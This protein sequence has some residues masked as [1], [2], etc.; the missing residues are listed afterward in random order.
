[1]N[2]NIRSMDENSAQSIVTWRYE[3]EYRIY[4]M[5]YSEQL[6]NEL[7]CGDYYA[8]FNGLTE[9]LIG[10]Y[11]FGKAAQVPVGNAFR[12]YD[13]NEYIDIGLG[14]KPDYC[15]I[16]LGLGFILQSLAFA[17]REL[18]IDRFRLTVALF[19]SR[20]IKLYK[21]IG[22]IEEISFKRTSGREDTIEFL[23]MILG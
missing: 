19:N 2:Y 21:K 5:E 23:T 8:V 3:D 22:F 6:I 15:G 12:A 13:D 14:M 18:H 7:L 20:A 11:C 17:K 16:G 4:N 9:E 1:M 10:F